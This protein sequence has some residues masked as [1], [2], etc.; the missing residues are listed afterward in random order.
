MT[1]KEKIQAAVDKKKG[2]DEIPPITQ[3]EMMSDPDFLG[4][5]KLKRKLD[6]AKHYCEAQLKLINPEIEIG[7][8]ASDVK[9]VRWD[10]CLLK[11]GNGRSPDRI[12]ATRLVE[13]GVPIDTIAAATVEGKTF[14]FPQIVPP[15]DA[16]KITTW[17]ELESMMPD[18]WQG[19]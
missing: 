4:K 9:G 12:S 15:K 18:G 3:F 14:T 16:A 7:L 6:M 19:E 1:V 11:Q 5:L 17:A 2:A 10:G 8:I 13:L